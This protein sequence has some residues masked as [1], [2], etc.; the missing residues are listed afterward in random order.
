VSKCWGP[1]KVGFRAGGG[2]VLGRT[3]LT[4]P[5][6]ER[7]LTSWPCSGG[8]GATLL[9]SVASAGR[10]AGCLR[11]TVFPGGEPGPLGRVTAP[12]PGCKY[13]RQR[14]I[15]KGKLAGVLG[16]V[17]VISAVAGRRLAHGEPRLHSLTNVF[18]FWRCD[19]GR[20]GSTGCTITKEA[21]VGA[22]QEALRPPCGRGRGWG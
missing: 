6:R 1:W 12:W 14:G 17:A 7:T 5:W 18:T 10:L 2:R 3:S 19:F 22:A 9:I 21:L 15:R 16:G 13:A 11:W 4:T 20:T 8:E